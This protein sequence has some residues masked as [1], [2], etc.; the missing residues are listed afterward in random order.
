MQPLP[1]SAPRKQSLSAWE[2][3]AG[4]RLH[5]AALVPPPVLARSAS[6]SVA[7]LAAPPP[8]QAGPAAHLA[9]AMLWQRGHPARWGATPPTLP[10]APV[11]SGAVPAAAVHSGAA[12]LRRSLVWQAPRSTATTPENMARA[13]A[14]PQV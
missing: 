13:A 4:L 9:R 10:A 1:T 6:P 2:E 5:P 12:L 7:P 11:I 8:R 3:Q 14:A